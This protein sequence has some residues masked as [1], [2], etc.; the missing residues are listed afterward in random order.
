MLINNVDIKN[1]VSKY[2]HFDSALSYSEG[3]IVIFNKKLFELKIPDDASKLY[4]T[5]ICGIE[6][7][8]ADDI[9]WK[10]IK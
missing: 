2:N 8:S 4:L 9:Y 6:P 10:E 3:S 7:N 1:K 5:L